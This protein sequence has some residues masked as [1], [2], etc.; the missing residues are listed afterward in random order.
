[1]EFTNIHKGKL[2]MKEQDYM[3]KLERR[4]QSL[5]EEG[6]SLKSENSSY[7]EQCERFKKDIK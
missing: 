2:I 1:M 7:K 6:H 4:I 3:A 5:K